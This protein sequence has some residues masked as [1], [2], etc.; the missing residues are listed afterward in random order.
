MIIDITKEELKIIMDCVTITSE[1]ISNRVVMVSNEAKER[2]EKIDLND[3]WLKLYIDATKT[4][5]VFEEL[6]F[7][8]KIFP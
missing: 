8:D 5:L 7:K 6:D 1:S 4:K 3:L 2:L